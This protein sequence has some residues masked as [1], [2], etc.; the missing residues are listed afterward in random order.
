MNSRASII[1]NTNNRLWLLKERSLPSALTQTYS[2]FEVIVVDNNSSDGTEEYMRDVAAK[3]PVVKYVR[4]EKDKGISASR[5]TG[6]RHASG[7]F[8]V[9]LDDDDAFDPR[10]L[11]VTVPVLEKLP[12]EYGALSV[13]TM[14]VMTGRTYYILKKLREGCFYAAVDDGWLMRRSVFEK[15]SWDEDLY[16]DEDAAF[17]IEF[18]K[19][20]KA[21]AVDEL[22]L[23]KYGI[24]KIGSHKYLSFSIP[25]EKR[26]RG[27]DNFVK[28][29][30]PEFERAG[31]EKQLVYI[32]RFIGQIY[33]MGG[34]IRRGLPFIWRAFRLKPNLRNT[35]NLIAALSGRYVYTLYWKVEVNLSHGDR[36]IK[37]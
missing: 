4:H 33:C 32:L 12:Q 22:L 24:R 27:L 9:F 18:F 37:K 30:L 36:A 1:L 34:E 6:V 8:V 2:N 7:D 3:N 20:Y 17:G 26:L 29:Y 14:M 5:N 28:K 25:S 23:F 16:Q 19:R 10:F 21:G 11:E 15:I 35:F 13:R 31:N